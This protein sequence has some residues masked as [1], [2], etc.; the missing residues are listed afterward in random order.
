MYRTNEKRKGGV[1]EQ[2]ARASPQYGMYEGDRQKSHN[3]DKR[4]GDPKVPL[5]EIKSLTVKE[6]LDYLHEL[7][8]GTMLEVIFDEE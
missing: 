3:S 1:N 4:R 5:H 6:A 7:P 8:A 2:N